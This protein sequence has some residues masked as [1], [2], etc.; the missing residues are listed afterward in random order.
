VAL[1]AELVEG[2][3]R[4]RM[5]PNIATFPTYRAHIT[6]AYIRKDEERRDQYLDLLRSA[7]IGREVAVR[8]INYGG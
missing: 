5:L 3:A 2:N 4:L 7:L 6:L 1:T 8:G